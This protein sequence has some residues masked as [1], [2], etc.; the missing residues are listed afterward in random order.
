MQYLIVYASHAYVVNECARC[1]LGTLKLV[2][3]LTKLFYGLY[4]FIVSYILHFR[5]ILTA[6]PIIGAKV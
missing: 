5:P 4:A 2:A 1:L 6:V 3:S